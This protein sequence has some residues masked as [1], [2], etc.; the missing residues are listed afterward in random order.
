MVAAPSRDDFA[1]CVTLVKDGARDL[2]LADLLLPDQI[3]NDIAAIHAFHVEITNIALS[4]GEP[5]AGQI[6][7]QWWIDVL[8]GERAS[9]AGGNPLS[10]C[11]LD[12][13]GRHKL[14]VTD[15][16]AKLE[17]HVFDLY[18]D[19]MGDRTMFEGYCGETRSCL[20]QWAALI[21]GTAPGSKLAD[22]SGHGGVATGCVSILE[23]I[24]LHHSR[25]QCFVPSDLLAA[26]G[27]S[28]NEYL[29]TPASTHEQVI[30]TLVDLAVEHELSALKAVNEL[31]PQVRPVFKP[32]ALVPLYLQRLKKAPLAAFKRREPVSQ[33]RSQWALL[34]F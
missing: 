20:F 28:V 31:G 7:I 17:A 24:G 11:L 5:M 14:P 27:L 3:R 22:A 13:I 9:E 34:R 23:N 21:A 18:Q 8:Q 26:V 19:P 6:R 33:W 32:L 2:Y 15:F 16:V 12:V 29:A 4:L 25:G 30:L 10:R 1:Y